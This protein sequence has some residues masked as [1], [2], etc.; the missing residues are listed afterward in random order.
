MLHDILFALFKVK[1]FLAIFYLNNYQYDLSGVMFL[2]ST[3]ISY[4]RVPNT[5]HLSENLLLL[6]KSMIVCPLFSMQ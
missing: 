5:K 3:V 4:N 6:P 2:L 1:D